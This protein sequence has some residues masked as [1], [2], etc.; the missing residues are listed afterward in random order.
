MILRLFW[1]I[2]DQ[3]RGLVRVRVV[4]AHQPYED[5]VEA[6]QLVMHMRELIA[7]NNFQFQTEYH[8]EQK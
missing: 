8:E 3:P 4:I 1:S 2:Y 5:G 7:L 6:G